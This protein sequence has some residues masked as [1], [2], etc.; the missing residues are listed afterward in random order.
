[1]PA[2]TACARPCSTPPA[3]TPAASWPLPCSAITGR[4]GAVWPGGRAIAQFVATP[5]RAAETNE[6]STIR[7]LD[8][9]RW[10]LQW[11]RRSQRRTGTR[12]RHRRPGNGRALRVQRG[13]QGERAGRPGRRTDTKAQNRAAAQFGHAGHHAIGVS[14]I[15][16]NTASRTFT[17]W[18]G[19]ASL[20]ARVAITRRIRRTRRSPRAHRARRGARQWAAVSRSADFPE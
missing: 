15:A 19:S 12:H 18:S 9:G 1:M 6:P 3:I 5:P 14:M 20:S 2:A 13:A 17:S 7:R 4:S 10:R 8:G 16:A 11:R